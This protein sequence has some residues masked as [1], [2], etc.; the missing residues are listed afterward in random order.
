MQTHHKIANET[1]ITRSHQI[2]LEDPVQSRYG[3][4]ATLE[5]SLFHWQVLGN[6]PFTLENT[7][8]LSRFKFG[9]ISNTVSLSY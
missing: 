5:I 2:F 9:D 3:P 8:S 1:V 7:K 4:S 6:A